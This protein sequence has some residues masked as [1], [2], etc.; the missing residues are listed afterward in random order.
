M[1]L[2]P[3][4]LISFLYHLEMLVYLELDSEQDREELEFDVVNK[5]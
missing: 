4:I 2:K 3:F 5:Y 1:Q